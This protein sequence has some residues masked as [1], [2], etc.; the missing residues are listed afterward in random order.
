MSKEHT[1]S[2]CG[3][4]SPLH[5]QIRIVR[6]PRGKRL[7]NSAIVF[8]MVVAQRMSEQYIE[9]AALAVAGNSKV[10]EAPPS[11]TIISIDETPEG[12][13]VYWGEALIDMSQI[14]WCVKK[15]PEWKVFLRVH[16][17]VTH[18]VVQDAMKEIGNAG[19]ADIIFGTW[20]SAG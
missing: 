14:G 1:A 9:L 13:K 19:Q 10:E 8:F 2:G 3:E 5:H 18:A 11:R 20:Q 4:T 15:N 12:Q 6:Y 7:I 17:K 16:P